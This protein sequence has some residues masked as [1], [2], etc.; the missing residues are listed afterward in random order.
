MAARKKTAR[1]AT[2]RVGSARSAL[3]R[4]ELPRNLQEFRKRIETQLNALER[5]VSRARTETRRRAAR[6][7]REASQQLG[8]LEARG[9]TGWRQLAESYRKDLVRL[10]ERIERALTPKGGAARAAR[11]TGARAKK[12]ATS[13]ARAAQESVAS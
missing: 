5:D 11:K 3:P 10:L 1:K 2:R 6:L 12:A 8:R 4:L 13:A 7:I 9:E